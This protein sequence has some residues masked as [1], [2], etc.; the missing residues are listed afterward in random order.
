VLKLNNISIVY[1][2]GVLL[3]ISIVGVGVVGYTGY[4][5]LLKANRDMNSMYQDRLIAVKLI[6]ENI[7]HFRFIQACMFEL[8]VTI[9][10]ARKEAVVKAIDLRDDAFNKNIIVYEKNNLDA[11]EL[12]QVKEMKIAIGKYRDGRKKI[13]ELAMQNK[14]AEAYKEYVSNVLPYSNVF[15]DLLKKIAEDNTKEAVELNKQNS[16]A[17]VRAKILIGGTLIGVLGTMGFFGFIIGRNITV[18]MRS[19]T[20]NLR[21]MAK[22][23]FSLDVPK[24]LLKNKDEFGIMGQDL[25]LLNQNMRKLVRMISHSAQQL[26]ATSEQLTASAEQSADASNQV[27]VSVTDIAQ[28]TEKQ[29]SAL[30]QT[31]EVMQEMSRQIQIVADN[32]EQTAA[33]SKKTAVAAQN[34]TQSVSIALVQMKNI[35]R[36]VNTSAAVVTK[37]GERSQEIGQIVDAISTIAGQTNLLALNA[38]IEAARAGEMGRGF[39]VVAEEVRRLA[40]QSQEAAEQISTLIHEIRKETDSAV[41]AMMAGTKEV[42]SGT[43]AV[44]GATIA[45]SEIA[46][47]VNSVSGQVQTISGAMKNLLEG[48]QQVSLSMKNAD[49]ISKSTSMEAQNVSSATEEQ[50]AAADEIASSSRDLAKLAEELQI[51]MQQFKI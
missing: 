8:M 19:G 4:S 12:E 14:N 2:L 51:T 39:A 28:G 26:A 38:A 17:F 33:L 22:G 3:I 32:T 35:E 50:S 27:A 42:K 24:N 46:D 7:G 10:G 45:F 29:T 5:H 31:T 43:V 41:T 25:D 9:D 1:K 37:L 6:N 15:I 23:N 20:S 16:E 13:I 36:T 34:G 49:D 11:K 21:E 47:L 44:N 30:Q 40:E 48:S 18:P